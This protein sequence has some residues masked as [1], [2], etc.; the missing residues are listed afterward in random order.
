MATSAILNFSPGLMGRFGSDCVYVL[1][2]DPFFV[3]NVMDMA[4]QSCSRWTRKYQTMQIYLPITI[5]DLFVLNGF[6]PQAFFVQ[7]FCTD[8][9]L[10]N[11][12]NG[13]VEEEL[14][15]FPFVD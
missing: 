12:E 7:V 15:Q 11:A 6:I 8:T 9:L 5:I 13:E 2:A 4:D 3:Y 10:K 1:P 14:K